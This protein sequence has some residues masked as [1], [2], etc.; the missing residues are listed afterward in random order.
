MYIFTV[1]GNE[2]TTL[3]LHDR[4][5]ITIDKDLLP[6]MREGLQDAWQAGFL[7]DSQ[8]LDD[9]HITGM[10]LGW[11]V[12]GIFDVEM[13]YRDLS[14]KVTEISPLSVFRNHLRRDASDIR[15]LL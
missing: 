12:P 4:E 14:L 2:F 15:K 1:G 5:W 7:K 8:S 9:C 3:S 6:F 13:Q 11:K 10:N